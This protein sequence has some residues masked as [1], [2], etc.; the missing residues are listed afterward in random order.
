[1]AVDLQLPERPRG[2][3]VVVVAI[4]DDGGLV[5]DA[6]APEQIFELLHRHDVADNRVAQFRGPVPAG[7]ARH[8]TLIVGGGV[9]VDFDDAHAGIGGVLGHP[10]RAHQHIG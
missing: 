4:Q 9:D 10:F 8:V 1:M 3:P 5:V 7:C 2:E 6:G